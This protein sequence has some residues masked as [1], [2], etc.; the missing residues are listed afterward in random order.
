MSKDYIREYLDA[1][2]S[3]LNKIYDGQ[4]AKIREYAEIIADRIE[5]DGLI[6]VFG[7]G[8]HSNM[9]NEELFHRAGG[10][11]CISPIFVDSIRIPHIPGGERCAGL[12][13]LALDFYDLKKNDVLILVNAYGI[14]PITI[15]TC[16]L[17]KE[18]G[19]KIIVVTSKE[20]GERLPRNFARRH[21]SG[22]NLFEIA[23]NVIFGEVPYGDALVKVEGVE[24]N[25]G[26]Y[27]TFANAFVCNS[28]IIET[29]RILT[30]RGIEPPVINSVNV[31]NGF[32]KNQALYKKYK[33]RIR[34]L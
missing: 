15:E 10:L 17:A 4:S 25:V 3:R 8:G 23:D 27:S 28:L 5:E 2:V 22:H 12:A 19:V 14:N 32:E 26:P 21:E 7:S 11:A 33:P 18:R 30:E 9:I 1:I 6:Y 34:F 31:E 24:S 13:R 29:C 16:L 20:Y